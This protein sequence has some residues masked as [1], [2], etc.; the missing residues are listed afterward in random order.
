MPGR[1]FAGRCRRPTRK[2]PLK[3]SR[4]EIASSGEHEEEEEEEEEGTRWPK[5]NGYPTRAIGLEVRDW[6]FWAA[7]SFVAEMG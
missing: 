5:K 6:P 1:L 3:P 4:A 2:K 7:A